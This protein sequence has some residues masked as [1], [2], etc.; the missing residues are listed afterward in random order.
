MGRQT[1]LQYNRLANLLL[2]TLP[3][4]IWL[5]FYFRIPVFPYPFD[6]QRVMFEPLPYRTS[7]VEV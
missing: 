6:S 1:D 7:Q 2:S 4:Q 5:L 3:D